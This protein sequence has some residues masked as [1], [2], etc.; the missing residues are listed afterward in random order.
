[1]RVARC[2]SAHRR[3]ELTLSLLSQAGLVM[4]VGSVQHQAS[5]RRVD[6]MDGGHGAGPGVHHV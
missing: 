3:R 1:M 4:G 5:E 2:L 6:I